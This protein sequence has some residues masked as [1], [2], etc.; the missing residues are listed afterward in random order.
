MDE[1][2]SAGSAS[3]YVFVGVVMA[4]VKLGFVLLRKNTCVL[5]TLPP[6]G[7]ERSSAWLP[8]KA[9]LKPVLSAWLVPS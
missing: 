7:A 4:N 2:V 8:S 5:P 6:A 1:D 9:V 3:P